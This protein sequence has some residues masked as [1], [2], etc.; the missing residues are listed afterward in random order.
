MIGYHVSM[1]SEQL[2]EDSGYVSSLVCVLTEN[3][4]EF[5]V[6]FKSNDPPKVGSIVSIDCN[7][8]SKNG[9]PLN[10]RLSKSKTKTQKTQKKEE[11]QPKTIIA[12]NVLGPGEHCHIQSKTDPKKY[13]KITRPKNGDSV[14][15]SCPAWKFQR[16]NPLVRTC[17]HL[18]EYN[19][20]IMSDDSDS[21][22]EIDEI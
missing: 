3:K 1:K 7:G 13:Y 16:K 15:C 9:I 6:V 12:V 22:F 21:E 14:Y 2:N 18:D 8:L 17:K 20:L 10:S 11:E 19:M 5:R 4:K